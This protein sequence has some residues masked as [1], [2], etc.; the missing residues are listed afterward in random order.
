MDSPQTS[1]DPKEKP[2]GKKPPSMSL[3][4][5]LELLAGIEGLIFTPDQQEQF[6]RMA[7]D[8]V[9]IGIPIDGEGPEKR[10]SERE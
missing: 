5:A 4:G 3:E 9:Q 2:V 8:G 6:R 1:Q 10:S 7:E